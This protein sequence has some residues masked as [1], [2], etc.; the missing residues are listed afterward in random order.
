MNS[1]LSNTPAGYSTPSVALHWLML[2]LIVATYA[3]MDLKGIYPRGSHG[4]E[5]MAAWHYMF[6]MTVFALV[7]FR[8]VARSLGTAPE[9]N[10]PMPVEQLAISKFVHWSL[11]A[12][13]IG[14]PVLGWL[15]VSAKGGDIPFWGFHLPALIDKDK[16]VSMLFKNIHE[17]VATLGYFLIGLHAAA[18]LFH[19]YVKGDNT[20]SL[21]IPR[22]RRRAGD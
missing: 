21:M 16:D 19:Y 8:L 1:K 3:M 15:T 6:G 20:L 18:A 4:R 5:L 14:L 17:P 22:L 12:L 9:V 13:M 10:P 11:Y 2:A 7:W